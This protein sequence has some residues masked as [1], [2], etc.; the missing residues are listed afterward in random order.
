MV[1]VDERHEGIRLEWEY[2]A[3]VLDRLFLVIFLT[4]AIAVTGGV[5]IVGWLL[6]DPRS[7]NIT[8][9]VTQG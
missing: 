8:S 5:F 3:D 7:A 9:S 6:E 4:L 1:T 2:L